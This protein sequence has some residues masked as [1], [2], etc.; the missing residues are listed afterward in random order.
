MIGTIAWWYCCLYVTEK[1]ILRQTC[2]GMALTLLAGIP[3]AVWEA[4]WLVVPENYDDRKVAFLSVYHLH[5]GTMM[6]DGEPIDAILIDDGFELLWASW[7][8]YIASGAGV[9]SDG[10]AQSRVF[11]P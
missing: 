9:C 2:E 4:F 5:I 7:I 3:F 6:S 11:P 1:T 8:V 10:C